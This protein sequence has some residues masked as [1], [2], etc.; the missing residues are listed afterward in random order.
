MFHRYVGVIGPL[1]VST[2][3]TVLSLVNN[4]WFPMH[5]MGLG[6]R[7]KRQRIE[8]VVSDEFNLK[9]LLVLVLRFSRSVV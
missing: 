3:F 8:L 6:R 9:V 1:S 7:K 5:M 4:L 2:A